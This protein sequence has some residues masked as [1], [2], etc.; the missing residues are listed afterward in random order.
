MDQQKD[1]TTRQDGRQD[2]KK[3]REDSSDTEL[4]NQTS[5]FMSSWWGNDDTGDPR[6]GR[7]RRA[8]IIMKI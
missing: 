6:E 8:K 4:E 2:R 7:D 5:I 3:R 1:G